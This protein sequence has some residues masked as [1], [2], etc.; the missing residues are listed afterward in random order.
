MHTGSRKTYLALA[1]IAVL[2]WTLD[3]VFDTVFAH[4]GTFSDFF[5]LNVP[6]SD[7]LFRLLFIAVVIAM[8]AAYL[9]QEARRRSARDEL[10]RHLT[11]IETSMDG[12]ALFDDQHVYRYANNAYARITGFADPGDL[13]GRTFAVIYD[14][15]QRAWIGENVFPALER[16]GR[17]N[18]E[19]AARRRNGEPFTQEASIARLQ[20]GG[21]VCVMR[22]ITDRKQRD[23]EL[24]R[25]G[26]FLHTIFDSIRDPFC[27]FDRDYRIVRANAAYA[28]LKNKVVG[29]LIDRT[30]FEVL[31]GRRDVCEGCVIRKTL[32]SGDPCAK[33]KQVP[34]RSGGTQWL[35]IY[36]YPMLDDEGR[37]THVVEYTRDITDRK[38]LDDDRKR[39]IDRLEHLSRT[40]G[41]TGLLNRRALTDHLAYEI[42]R[43][44][45]YGGDLSLILCDLDN[46][47]VINDTRGHLAGDLAI[48]LLSATVR[49]SVRNVDFV[50][51]YGGDEFLVIVPGTG[52][53]GA[54]SMAEKI[55]EVMGRTEA[56]I[57]GGHPV[58]VSVSIGIAGLSPPD[59]IDRFISR[60]DAALYASKQAGRNR[61]TVS[62]QA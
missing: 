4:R 56:G 8:I 30:C 39:L 44:R 2:L 22:D 32:Q 12:I 50:G 49:N 11:A 16:Q 58:A 45:R 25:S 5:A 20:D 27:I 61:I 1:G 46:L 17:W 26:R 21:C 47:K 36:T 13:L 53:E 18:G 51:R 52:P 48:Q 31:E 38:R 19:I 43:V 29:D 23:E 24:Q 14:E 55:Q 40:D 57:G 54:R 35:E 59:T 10:H 42:E 28:E 41:L 9:K 3:T 33:E 6:L 34:L 62:D 7:I 60:V 37:V 15:Q